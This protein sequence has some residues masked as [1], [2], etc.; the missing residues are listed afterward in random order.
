MTAGESTYA[1]I[2]RMVSAAHTAKA[3]FVRMRNAP[4]VFNSVFNKAP[5]KKTIQ[6]R[7]WRD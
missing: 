7:I 6:R 5:P 4:T 2:V 1:G 3:P